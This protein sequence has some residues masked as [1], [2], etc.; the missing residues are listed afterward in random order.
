MKNRSTALKSG[1]LLGLLLVCIFCIGMNRSVSAAT[2]RTLLVVGETKQLSGKGAAGFT[3]SRPAVAS[4][5]ADG[6][7]TAHRKGTC[8][9]SAVR[10]NQKRTWKIRVVAPQPGKTERSIGVNQSFSLSL[11]NASGLKF[12][13]SVSDPTVLRLKK[14]GKNRYQV[15]G[16]KNG[17]A[18]VFITRGAYQTTCSVTVGS[19]TLNEQQ[20]DPKP[21]TPENSDPGIQTLYMDGN[22]FKQ[23]TWNRTDTAVYVSSI[24][25]YGQ[26]APLY[27][28]KDGGDGLE[29]I[30]AATNNGA[31]GVPGAKLSAD[32]VRGTIDKACLW[33]RA[34]ADSPYHGYDYGH[35]YQGANLMYTFGQAKPNALGTGDYCCSTIPLCA[36]YFAGVNVIG[37][38]LGGPDA[39]YIPES[40]KLF[41]EG[42]WG[43]ITFYENGQLTGARYL[44]N[45]EWRIFAACGFT[46]VVSAYRKNPDTFQFRAGDVV[47]ANGHSQI[48]L[49]SGTRKTAETVQAYGHDKVKK[50][51]MPKGGDQNYEIG[52]AYGIR[53]SKSL[54]VMHIMRFTGEGVRLNTVGLRS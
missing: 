38:N 44:S 26:S 3:S 31:V 9:V 35:D 15:T 43:E 52:R 49:T 50:G 22:V 29:N 42:S 12:N 18:I 20:S 1:I 19:G 32:A 47:T 14:K 28:H 5:T 24:S 7:V 53:S 16:L 34:I 13:W 46:D 21:V 54:P 41:Y 27:I 51:Q 4:V 2:R 39:K 6:L 45:Y 37:E 11:K 33:A 48:V 23:M 10:N 25:N 30:W 36:Y 40:T 17:S 8:R